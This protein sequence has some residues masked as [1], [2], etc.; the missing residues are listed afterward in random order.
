M[1]QDNEAKAAELF[2][3]LTISQIREI[4]HNLE[5]QSDEK[6]NELRTLVGSKY[7]SLLS[8]AENIMLMNKI[9]Q[10]QDKKLSDL[11]ELNDN[12]TGNLDK[13]LKNYHVFIDTNVLNTNKSNQNN[14]KS[15]RVAF[16]TLQS[17][18]DGLVISVKN[19]LAKNLN[20]NPLIDVKL[21]HISKEF[22]VFEKLLVK[23]E[24]NDK[25]NTLYQKFVR[26]KS[27]YLSFLS[28]LIIKS[29]SHSIEY[30]N[31]NA[32][33]TVL[34]SL[35]LVL[36]LDLFG[37][38]K[39]YIDLKSKVLTNL[40]EHPAFVNLKNLSTFR[41]TLSYLY[42]SL[43]YL[44]V[45]FPD[46]YGSFP[47]TFLNQII[48]N[49]NFQSS[50]FKANLKSKYASIL[51]NFDGFDEFLSSC[52]FTYSMSNYKDQFSDE[53]ALMDI[54]KLWKSEIVNNFS[55][56]FEKGLNYAI[57]HS[58]VRSGKTHKPFTRLIDLIKVTV[59]EFKSIHSSALTTLMLPNGDDLLKN[60]IIIWKTN[61]TNILAT[62]IDQIMSVSKSMATYLHTQ[63]ITEYSN[64]GLWSTAENDMQIK[65]VNAY[66]LK[67]SS[68]TSMNLDLSKKTTTT[69]PPN[70]INVSS[71]LINFFSN[72]K[73][74]LKVF[75]V[76][77]MQNLISNNFDSSGSDPM[78]H[79]M[80]INEEFFNDHD[81]DAYQ[82]S[83]AIETF[84]TEYKDHFTVIYDEIR[85]QYFEKL[86]LERFTNFLEQIFG[87]VSK[88]TENGYISY[89]DV[90]K[91]L[92]IFRKSI[93][94]Q[95]LKD[96]LVID[97]DQSEFSSKT[98]NKMKESISFIFKRT[99]EV[100]DYYYSRITSEF[101]KELYQDFVHIVLK[102]FL[103]FDEGELEKITI[104]KP[105]TIPNSSFT[106]LAA[107][108]ENDI[109][110]DTLLNT[111]AT[112]VN[113][114]SIKE[115]PDH[116]LH[117]EMPTE[118]EVWEDGL[119]TLPSTSV[120]LLLYNFC[121]FLVSGDKD[122]IGSDYLDL[123]KSPGFKKFRVKIII[124]LLTF[125]KETLAVVS[126]TLNEDKSSSTQF[127]RENLLVSLADFYHLLNF[128]GTEGKLQDLTDQFKQIL[129]D[130][131]KHSREALFT[132]VDDK[133]ISRKIHE[134]FEQERLLYLPLS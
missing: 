80:N 128:V 26:L 19:H 63:P 121:E 87:L 38:L 1:V 127:L 35:I 118:K 96:L 114:S 72:L 7:R 97:S 100:I 98:N 73:I 13:L 46:K 57:E 56:S 111:G 68:L 31:N 10:D 75:N 70:L 3:S 88:E 90:L 122:S 101:T 134:N 53:S 55:K 23:I 119:P 21:I 65:D 112:A 106:T 105:K 115:K 25:R 37:I 47:K 42:L 126:E 5:V 41:N 45:F 49:L 120:S 62:Q 104:D 16:L 6:T 39:Y 107:E 93:K 58:S 130:I 51:N 32:F 43:T 86:L 81:F 36:N 133:F 44:E 4:S 110:V 11:C 60:L 89:V 28:G 123:Y 83:E 78:I 117:L 48:K 34:V 66:L 132:E 82:N 76:G 103:S 85:E 99:N 50:Q 124:T 113:F 24:L 52:E 18:I 109:S 95:G 125:F 91:V 77:I 59:K 108:I 8:T 14:E 22:Y 40:F 102:R 29:N 61:I 33:I 79:E 17:S 69:S 27:Q 92:L 20:F 129:N 84:L 67:V 30:L 9:V 94:D 131:A 12:Q 71:E 74:V 116:E 2:R 54:I 64:E 15:L